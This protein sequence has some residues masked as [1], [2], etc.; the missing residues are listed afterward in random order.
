MGWGTIFKNK[1]KINH[2]YVTVYQYDLYNIWVLITIWKKNHNT[3]K[4]KY[5]M[6]FMVCCLK[7]TCF[8]ARCWHT[9]PQDDH[10]CVAYQQLFFVSMGRSENH[11]Y[12]KGPFNLKLKMV[13]AGMVTLV[14][15]SRDET[16]HHAWTVYRMHIIKKSV[17]TLLLSNCE[18]ALI[19]NWHSQL[20]SWA[21]SFTEK[22]SIYF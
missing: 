16:W 13:F 14:W 7:N 11:Y 6:G 17:G 4:M 1:I 18:N 22:K 20:M 12:G 15:V 5:V 3:L 21:I 2:T 8:Y 10:D 19:P 9:S